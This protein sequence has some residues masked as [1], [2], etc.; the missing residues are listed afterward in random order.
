MGSCIICGT[1]VDGRICDLHDQDVVFEFR[2][3]RPEQLTNGRYYRGTVDGFAE[4]GVFVDIG[5]SVTGLLHQ[6]ELDQRLESLDWEAGDS[7][8]VQVTNVRDN[9][10]VDLGWSIRQSER[11][12]RGTLIDDPAAEH[13][14]LADDTPA[15]QSDSTDDERTAPDPSPVDRSDQTATGDSR[16][17]TAA[18]T[19]DEPDEETESRRTDPVHATVDGL[20][21][22]V[23]EFVRLEGE[24]A[25][26]RQTSG[27]TIFSLRDETGTVECAAFESAG[28]RAYPEVDEGDIVRI[29]GEVE[30]RRGDIQVETEGLVVL[31]A[32]ERAAVTE[33]IEDALIERARPAAVDP[34]AADEA[35]EAIPEAL[36]D[37]ATAIRRAVIEGRPVIVRHSAGVDGYLG[38]AAIE[39]ATLPLVRDEHQAADA[40][41]HYFD[42]RPLEGTVYDLDDA[43][44]DVTTMLSNEAR[45]GEQVPLFVFV[46]AGGTAESLDGLELLSLYDASTVVVEAEPVD[47]GISETA[48]ISV[49]APVEAPDTTATALAANV[50]AHVNGDVRDDLAHLPAA[51]FW[52]ETPAPYEA[53]ATDV[54]Y[55]SDDVRDLREAVALEA[56]YQSYEDKRE[57]IADLLFGETAA[58]QPS[59]AAHVSEQFRTRMDQAVETAR[60]NIETRESE[61]VTLLVLDTDAYTHRYEFPPTRLLLDELFRRADPEADALVGLGTDEA[62][63][64][65]DAD[66]DVRSVVEAARDE[67]PAA[68]IDP[69]GAREG[70]IEFLAGERPAV[71]EAV[72]RALASELSS[73]AAA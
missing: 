32:E 36:R 70:R 21:D 2:G 20:P 22:L 63:V 73:V 46:G 6:S 27:P 39:R 15:D 71:R 54:S 9:G 52:T 50:A 62:Y 12:F 55:S 41:Y 40:E 48:T 45:H 64:R 37:A 59:L 18:D 5:D 16:D 1:S 17:E 19:T 23:G 38:G 4:F 8:F 58:D 3:D 14:V 25:E 43:T 13:E 57:L 26:T 44:G 51:S 11:E 66:L 29:E 31:E 24:I 28:V 47:E 30:E 53:L 35:V 61:G 56:Y 42:R 60:A 49:A 69:R 10:N 67:A 34:L 65:A 33:R 68:G 7:V 72:L